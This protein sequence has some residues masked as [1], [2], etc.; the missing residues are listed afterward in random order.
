[1]EFSTVLPNREDKERADIREYHILYT[2]I[3]DTITGG[4]N[5]EERNETLIKYDRLATYLINRY[6]DLFNGEDQNAALEFHKF[7]Q[8]NTWRDTPAQVFN[9]LSKHHFKLARLL[10]KYG[11]DTISTRTLDL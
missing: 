2:K 9:V 10:R 4:E 11:I 8:N 7:L 1:M 3:N 5:E 6:Q